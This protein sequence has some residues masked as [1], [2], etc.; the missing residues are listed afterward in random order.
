MFQS[1]D[2]VSGLPAFAI[3]QQRKMGR[4]YNIVVLRALL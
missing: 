2:Y 4:E 3:K 1:A